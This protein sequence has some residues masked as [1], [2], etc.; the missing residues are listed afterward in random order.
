M[1]RIFF[2]RRDEKPSKLVTLGLIAMLSATAAFFLAGPGYGF[3]LYGDGDNDSADLALRFKLIWITGIA[4]GFGGTLTVLG[5]VHSRLAPQVR[6]GGRAWLALALAVMVGWPLYTVSV[7]VREAAPIH[8]VTTDLN[9][10]PRFTAIEPRRYD[11]R[12]SDAVR[13]GRLDPRHAELH[14]KAYGDLGP[15]LV[16]TGVRQTIVTAARVAEKLG[17]TVI[18]SQPGKG[19]IEATD[20][21][22]WFNFRYN[23]AIRVTATDTGS[24]IDLRALS[25]VGV[26]DFGASARRLRAF[27]KAY[28][29]GE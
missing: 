18:V 16:D 14:Q 1:S 7:Q 6:A 27:L 5:I 17:W 12:D 10:P 13:G 20:R 11:A 22:L 19:H 23:I 15:L 26:S 8:D 9:N 2:N 29:A 4:L 3:G 24:R 28:P 21:S 25:A